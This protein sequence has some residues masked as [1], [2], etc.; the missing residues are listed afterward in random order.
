MADRTCHESLA[1]PVHVDD[2]PN[3]GSGSDLVG[4]Q[5]AH[6]GSRVV[7]CCQLRFHSHDTHGLF[8]ASG[9][10]I[11]PKD[12]QLL[13]LLVPIGAESLEDHG[14]VLEGHGVEM[15]HRLVLFQQAVVQQYLG[16]QGF[17]H[18]SSLRVKQ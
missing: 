17:L 1:R 5:R 16:N 3:M 4:L 14:A 8:Q 13:R 18:F 11:K 15:D 9:V 12:V 7:G 2:L 10:V 6:H